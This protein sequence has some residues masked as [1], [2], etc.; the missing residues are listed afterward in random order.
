MA[1][2]QASRLPNRSVSR[3]R[4]E[5]IASPMCRELDVRELVG[6][7]QEVTL[8]HAGERYR[9]RITTNNKLILTK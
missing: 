1:D 7:N 2:E 8:P 3:V 9:L 4:T 6:V 5:R